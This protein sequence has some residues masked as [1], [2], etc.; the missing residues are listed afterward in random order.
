MRRG[1]PRPNLSRPPASRA[2]DLTGLARCSAP[3]TEA[4]I[5]GDQIQENQPP[6]TPEEQDLGMGADITR[7]D[8]L[9]AVA[10]GTGAALLG[11]PA[12]AFRGP[13]HGRPLQPP[14]AEPGDAWHP[15]TRRRRDRGL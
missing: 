3:A 1:P 14:P 6:L 8:F 15:W 4:I 7:R 10:L 2:C 5:I 12:P 11:T 13:P 9:N